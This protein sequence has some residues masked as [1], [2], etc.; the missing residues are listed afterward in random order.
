MHP[1]LKRSLHWAGATLGLAGA[2]F[3]AKRMFDSAGQ[4]DFSSFGTGSWAIVAA[5]AVT[6]GF[7]N[8]LLALGWWQILFSLHVRTPRRWAV[9]TYGIS[10][11][12]KYVPGNVFHFG[13]RQAL[14]LAAGLPGG[15]L[16]KSALWELALASVAGVLFGV[17]ALPLQWSRIPVPL[18][19]LAFVSAFSMVGLSAHRWL[20]SPVVK[21][22]GCRA[23]FL[24]LSGFVFVSTL[25]V[26][27]AKGTLEI[28]LLPVYV[29][30]YVV[31]WLAGLVTPG[32]PAGVGVREVVLLFMFGGRVVEAELLLAVVISR[33]ITV[34]GDVGFFAWA[35]FTN[36][37]S[38]WR[39]QD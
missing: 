35:S 15:A 3:V 28:E 22:L 10:Q 20:G 34:V 16:V 2:I 38:S 32:A 18:S 12:A 23:L 30:A 9:Q 36:F 13:S 26:V 37:R 17:L 31:A 21:A 11:L 1:L 14:G 8:C 29:G 27:T 24:L 5:L 25:S 7:A 4:I 33:A 39:A 19:L 6:F